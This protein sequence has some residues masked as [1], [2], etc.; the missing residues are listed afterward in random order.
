MGH[1][2]SG[3]LILGMVTN[4]FLESLFVPERITLP[5]V[6]ML[7]NSCLDFHPT[8]CVAFLQV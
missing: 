2:L 6:A 3:I 7:H 8:A 5:M 4:Q 1:V